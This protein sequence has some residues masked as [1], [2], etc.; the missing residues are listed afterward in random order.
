[1]SEIKTTIVQMEIIE[2]KKK[3][4]QNKNNEETGLLKSQV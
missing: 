1:M 2:N 4:D 3:E